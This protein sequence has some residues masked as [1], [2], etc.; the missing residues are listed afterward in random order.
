MTRRIVENP[1]PTSTRPGGPTDW[2]FG[3]QTSSGALLRCGPVG[4]CPGRGGRVGVERNEGGIC[5][6]DAPRPRRPVLRHRRRP[7]RLRDRRPDPALL[8]GPVRGERQDA[9]G[10]AGEPRRRPV[11]LRP[12]LG[13]SLGPLRAPAD[14]ARHDRRDG[15]GPRLPGPRRLP[16]RDLRRP[17]AGRRLRLEHQ[18]RDGLP[19]RRDGRGGPDPLDGDDR[20]ELRRRL[21]PGPAARGTALQAGPGRAHVRGGGD[22]GGE[23]RLGGAAPRGARAARGP[24]RSGSHQ[25]PRRAAGAP[26]R[27]GLPD[28]L[29]LFDRRHAARDDLRLLPEPPL[30]ARRARRGPRDAR[31][32]HRDGRGPGRR[33]EAALGPLPGAA[34]RDLGPSR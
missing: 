31:H 34:A 10:A 33:D 7:D 17:P 32:G 18:R 8:G 11:R 23:P 6:S 2:F 20:R 24:A 13:T 21:H 15:R 5:G 28:L 26:D 19:D 22:G 1:P 3:R 12:A 29:P 30:R 9:R 27:A 25:P 4:E 14:H 16:G